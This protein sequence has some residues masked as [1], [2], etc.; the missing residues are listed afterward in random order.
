MFKKIIG[1]II[2]GLILLHSCFSYTTKPSLSNNELRH[3]VVKLWS[4]S[5]GMCSGEQIEAPSGM[6]YIL[7]AGHCAMLADSNGDIR[8]ETEDKEQLIRKVIAEDQESD[9]LLIEGLPNVKG[10][11]LAEGHSHEVVRTFTHGGNHDTWGSS[12]E[13]VAIKP[14]H[15]MITQIDPNSA[16]DVQS[17]LKAPK[18][19]M[20]VFKT[21]FGDFGACMLVADEWE[22]TAFVMPGSSGGMVVNKWGELV[23]VVSATDAQRGFSYF[24]TMTDIKRFLAAY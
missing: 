21:P 18:Y 20:Q 6:A 15:I 23:A 8:V 24:V 13:L 16:I 3:K 19:Q 2:V 17:C 4:Q 10:L 9:L 22:S 7:S 14:Q 11:Q 12:G 5:R 1:V